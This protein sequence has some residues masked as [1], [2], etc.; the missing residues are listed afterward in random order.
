EVVGGRHVARIV[1]AVVELQRV[2]WL[3]A[4]TDT[5]RFVL[6][7]VEVIAD[8]RV[9]YRAVATVVEVGGAH[10]E[11]VRE[12]HV[13]DRA[14]LQRVEVPE[15]QLLREAEGVGLWSPGHDA[16]RAACCVAPE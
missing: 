5:Q 11:H 4:G 2:R 15:T 10:G 8:A 13:E 14:R 9:L 16:D 3:P 12:R 6:P 1:E 7:F